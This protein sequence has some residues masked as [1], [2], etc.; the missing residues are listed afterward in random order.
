VG[1]D[2]TAAAVLFDFDGTLA[3]TA[4]DLGAALNRLRGREGLAPLDVETL[5]PY[6]SMGA[7]GMLRIGFS[8]TPHDGRYAGLREAFLH[9]Y[10]QV[11]CNDTC[12]FPGMR[13]LLDGL[14]K[15]GTP[16]GIVTNK[17]RRFAERIS[18]FLGVE[19]DVVVGGDD[20]P[21]FKPH[22]ASLLL[23]AEKLKITRESAYY[24]GDDLR[25]IQAARAAGMKPVA[26]EWGYISPDN[27]GP[28]AWNADLVISRPIE[29]LRYVT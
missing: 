26:V 20:T 29:L 4:P 17:A 3:D 24:L 13:E 25:D 22:P 14:E 8:L 16:W 6:A 23:A 7:R 11:L 5:R 2:Q 15:H 10:E 18:E 27:G 19:P 12:L 9:E 1:K 28:A 21:H